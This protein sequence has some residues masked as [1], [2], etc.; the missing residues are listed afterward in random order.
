MNNSRNL[1]RCR[2]E[3]LPSLV[4]IVFLLVLMLLLMFYPD[5][6]LILYIYMY[7]ICVRRHDVTQLSFYPFGCLQTVSLFSKYTASGFQLFVTRGKVKFRCIAYICASWRKVEHKMK[8]EMPAV[9][10]LRFICDVIKIRW[11]IPWRHRNQLLG[12][13]CR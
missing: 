12:L 6:T 4:L 8:K 9:R 11:C 5:S 1:G 13:V 2:F 3:R 10:F 7:H